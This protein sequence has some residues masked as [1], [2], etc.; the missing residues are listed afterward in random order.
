MRRSSFALPRSAS[1]LF[2]PESKEIGYSYSPAIFPF[3]FLFSLAGQD[4]I[5]HDRSLR[6]WALSI[7]LFSFG[8]LVEKLL[9]MAYCAN[10]RAISIGDPGLLLI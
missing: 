1:S 3:F 10:P 6:A 4:G 2:S 9:R 8:T 5:Q 7:V